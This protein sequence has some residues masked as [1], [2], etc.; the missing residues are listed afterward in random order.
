[1]SIIHELLRNTSFYSNH[2]E[3]PK[4]ECSHHSHVL[5]INHAQLE[6]IFLAPSS[7]STFHVPI[8]KKEHSLV[9]LHSTCASLPVCLP[10]IT[11]PTKPI[12][13]PFYFYICAVTLDPNVLSLFPPIF[14]EC[15]GSQIWM[16]NYLA[17]QHIRNQLSDPNLQRLAS[18]TSDPHTEFDPSLDA[19]FEDQVF[20]E[21]F[22]HCMLSSCSQ[23]YPTSTDRVIL[24]F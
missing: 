22:P 23:T 6:K 4:T 16:H 7:T 21:A 24:H 9:P 3:V 10:K 20:G 18:G 12:E 2:I 5:K 13:S 19:K 17:L 15:T 14:F 1:M 8:G 11:L